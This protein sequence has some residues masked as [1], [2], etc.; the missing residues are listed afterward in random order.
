[1]SNT[2]RN[3]FESVSRHYLMLLNTAVTMYC[4]IVN[5]QK[6]SGMYKSQEQC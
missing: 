1:M 4:V 6:K 3:A 2:V 5:E